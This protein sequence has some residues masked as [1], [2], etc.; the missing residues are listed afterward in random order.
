METE[1]FFFLIKS[2][3][4]VTD[5]FAIILYLLCRITKKNYNLLLVT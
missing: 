3:Y 2:N 1:E 5:L 4:F